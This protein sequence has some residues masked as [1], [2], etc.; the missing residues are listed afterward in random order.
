MAPLSFGTPIKSSW[1]RRWRYC[2]AGALIALGAPAGLFVARC[3]SVA[4]WLSYLYATV[5]SLCALAALGWLHGRK[6]D[7]LLETSITDPLTGLY[8]R[9]HLDA[10]VREEVARAQ[11]YHSVLTALVIDVDRLKEVNDSLGHAAGD[12]AIALVAEVVRACCR[13]GDVAARVGGDEFV[14]LAPCTTAIEGL[15]L[16]RRI[17]ARVADRVAR[18]ALGPPAPSI[19]IGVAD[20][21][22]AQHPTCDGL[23]A[24]ADDSLYVAK[25]RGGDRV[26]LARDARTRRNTAR[27]NAGRT[28]DYAGGEEY[29]G[30][31][32]FILSGSTVTT[33]RLPRMR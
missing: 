22:R 30:S 24:A 18:E 15:G 23:I 28:H 33:G 17:R 4:P 6:E 12:R 21:Q 26:V 7:Q 20:L 5:F 27:F 1:P 16:A 19:S 29:T 11:R 3:V 13:T 32:P 8:N 31:G 10:R 2:V 25:S 9:R 14:V